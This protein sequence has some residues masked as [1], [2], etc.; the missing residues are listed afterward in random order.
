MGSTWVQEKIELI[1]TEKME[2]IFY[3]K[4]SKQI[5]LYELACALIGLLT[6]LLIIMIVRW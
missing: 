2:A 3:E 4:A 5:L 1:E 6:G